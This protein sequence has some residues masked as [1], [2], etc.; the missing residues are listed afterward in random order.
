MTFS[1]ETT[2]AAVAPAC[3]MGHPT[4]AR[5]VLAELGI[6]PPVCPMDGRIR[7]STCTRRSA[8]PSRTVPWDRSQIAH[9]GPAFPVRNVHYAERLGTSDGFRQSL[10]G[11]GPDGRA[12]AVHRL[13]ENAARP[14]Q[15]VV[16]GAAH[17]GPSARAKPLSDAALVGTPVRSALQR[18]L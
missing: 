14:G 7:L 12:D 13:V 1:R 15:A 16:A 8:R 10:R 17:D 5:R 3:D 9:T 6:P 18:R 2:S 11:R 4:R